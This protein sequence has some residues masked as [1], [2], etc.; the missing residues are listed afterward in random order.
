MNSSVKVIVIVA[1][2]L[3][4]GWGF[5]GHQKINRLAVFTLPPE[6]IRFY[7]KNMQYLVETSTHPDSRRYAVEGEAP[8]HFIDLDKYGDSALAIL[9]KYWKNAVEKYGE[10][11]LAAH[12]VVPWHIVKMFNLLKQA[13]LVADPDRI[14]RY[15][16]ELGHYVGDAHVPLHTTSNYNG[17][18]TGQRGIHAF[19]ESR[20]PELFFDTY[21]FYVG[22]ASYINDPQAAAW[23]AVAGSSLLVDS[24]L[25]I[26]RELSEAFPARFNYET[27]A[28]QTTKVYSITFSRTY[29]KR[30][31][32]MVER[33]LRASIKL[34][35][36]LWYTAWVDAGQPD[37]GVLMH[38]SPTEE[39]L[40]LRQE[41]MKKWRER[42]FAAPGHEDSTN[43][44]PSN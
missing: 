8:R 29:H 20:L 4:S 33:R 44:D 2:C 41:E 40:K 19:W 13:F 17:Q 14:L 5:F 35:A 24:V 23:K 28:R 30:L 1:V 25:N 27:K 39:E 43:S 9:P 37:L 22:K 3:S 11:S 26:E 32:G 6:M 12:G 7:K 15:S 42:N 16:A 34:T 10:D 18:L 31:A 21:D 38:Y 36:D